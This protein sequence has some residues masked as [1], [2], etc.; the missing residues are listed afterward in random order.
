MQ[1]NKEIFSWS[2]ENRDFKEIRYRELTFNSLVLPLA[3]SSSGGLYSTSWLFGV[4]VRV[5]SASKL[6]PPSTQASVRAATGPAMA[7]N[8]S[9]VG[10]RDAAGHSAWSSSYLKQF[11]Y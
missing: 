8:G 5:G 7:V 3:E 10:G 2:F 9:L 1:L 11:S 4:L 6:S